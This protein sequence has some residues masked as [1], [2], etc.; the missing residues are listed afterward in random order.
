MDSARLD[1]AHPAYPA[2][3]RQL[4][5]DEARILVTLKNQTFDYVWTK[6]YDRST[7][8]F[9]ISTIEIDALPKKDL[10]FPDTSSSRTR[11]L[12]ICST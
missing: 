10:V 3:L 9:G 6:P 12:S 5:T 8:L 2:I 11:F 4:S 7:N 1:Q